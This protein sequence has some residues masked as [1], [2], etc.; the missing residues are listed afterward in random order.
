M[1]SLSGG[2]CQAI[3]AFA[4]LAVDS[5]LGSIQ[6]NTLEITTPPVALSGTGVSGSSYTYTYISPGLAACDNVQSLSGQQIRFS[7]IS[8]Q[9]VA[10]GLSDATTPRGQTSVP[11]LS[12]EFS[13]GFNYQIN[14][15]TAVRVPGTTPILNGITNVYF[16]TD[17]NGNLTDYRVGVYAA[18]GAFGYSVSWNLDS[19][20]HEMAS[21]PYLVP[22]AVDTFY[23]LYRGG[24]HAF[25]GSSGTWYIVAN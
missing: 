18:G 20:P 7:F 10:P 24:E 11:V 17:I 2:A 8:S 19:R 14:D 9:M 1:R 12:W 15:Q 25:T 13:A 5:N 6:F 21:C 3:I 23:G 16:S 4:P 22:G